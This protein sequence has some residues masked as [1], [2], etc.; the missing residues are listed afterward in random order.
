MQFYDTAAISQLQKFSDLTP[1]GS[2][3]LNDLKSGAMRCVNGAV[4]TVTSDLQQ[5]LHSMIPVAIAAIK[6]SGDL[7][8]DWLDFVAE[9]APMLA[10]QGDTIMFPNPKKDKGE[11]QLSVKKLAVCVA[12]LSFYPGG[13]RFC[14]VLYRSSFDNG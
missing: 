6:D 9:F 5:I 8:H 14:G 4:Y 11:W 10:E 3:L 1:D 13:L 7:P 2:Q 12:C